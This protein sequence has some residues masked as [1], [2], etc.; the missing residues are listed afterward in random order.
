MTEQR[1]WVES[2][3][4]CIYRG[5]CLASCF[6]SKTSGVC[7]RIGRSAS[8]NSDQQSVGV[9]NS[10]CSFWSSTI[11]FTRSYISSC[12]FFDDVDTHN[13]FH[14]GD[15][16]WKNSIGYLRCQFTYWP[17]IALKFWAVANIRFPQ[18]SPASSYFSDKVELVIIWVSVDFVYMA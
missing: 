18:Y 17:R 15:M 16:V 14:L 6:L 12:I 1:I 7:F 2:C 5:A 4:V 11:S 10:Y 8:R 9:F 3:R 13:A